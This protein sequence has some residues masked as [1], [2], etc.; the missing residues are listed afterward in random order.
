MTFEL[1]S[2]Q[3]HEAMIQKLPPVPELPPVNSAEAVDD[4]DDDEEREDPFVA[5]GPLAVERDAVVENVHE[6][7]VNANAGPLSV[8]FRAGY[9]SAT[10]APANDAAEIQPQQQLRADP[11]HPVQVVTGPG[12]TPQAR[13]VVQQPPS[14]FTLTILAIAL[15]IAILA[16]IIKKLMRS[17]AMPAG[18]PEH[19]PPKL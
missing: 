8:S 6:V 9:R 5:G 17:Q 16:L 1:G 7:D 12:T 15:T 4:D 14:D 13:P 2:L 10:R 18:M 3:I 19:M 11:A